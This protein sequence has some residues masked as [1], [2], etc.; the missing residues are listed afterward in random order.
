MIE[1]IQEILKEKRL[2]PSQ[3]ADEIKVQRS[4]MSHIL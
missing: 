2:S 1:R 3:F 4:G